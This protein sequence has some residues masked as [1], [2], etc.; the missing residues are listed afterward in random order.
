MSQITLIVISREGQK[1]NNMNDLHNNQIS[2]IAIAAV[3]LIAIASM[4][5]ISLS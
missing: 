2:A 3:T 5:V 4:T 1:I